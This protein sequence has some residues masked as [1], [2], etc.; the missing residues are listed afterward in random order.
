MHRHDQKVL[1][2]PLCN[3]DKLVLLAKFC[4]YDAF[5][6]IAGVGKIDNMGAAVKPT[7]ER[8]NHP[9]SIF[10]VAI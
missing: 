9:S 4:A 3:F 10:A 2:C 6:S 8:M 7:W 5:R 1:I